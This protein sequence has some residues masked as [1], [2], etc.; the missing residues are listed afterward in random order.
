MHLRVLVTW[1]GVANWVRWLCFAISTVAPTFRVWLEQPNVYRHE[2]FAIVRKHWSTVHAR[3][4]H[5]LPTEKYAA[6]F[7]HHLVITGWGASYIHPGGWKERS[8]AHLMVPFVSRVSEIHTPL[9]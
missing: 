6:Y 9:F 8:A 1:D 7:V 3:D 4:S 5:R 2:A